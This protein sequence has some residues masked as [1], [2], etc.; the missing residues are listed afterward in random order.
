MAKLDDL[1]T[2]F[3]ESDK[4]KERVKKA[5]DSF[6]S[7]FGVGPEVEEKLGME[8]GEAIHSHFDPWGLFENP[9]FREFKVA[10]DKRVI[11]DSAFESTILNA[12]LEDSKEDQELDSFSKLLGGKDGEV[13]VKDLN[14]LVMSQ[15]EQLGIPM[16]QKEVKGPLH[17]LDILGP[18]QA[19]FKGTPMNPFSTSFEPSGPNDEGIRGT[20]ENI[21]G[22]VNPKT[23]S[24]FQSLGLES[25]EGSLPAAFSDPGS[26]TPFGSQLAEATG[27]V[28]GLDAELLA[29]EQDPGLQAPVDTIGTVPDLEALLGTDEILQL[30]KAV[31]VRV[32][33]PQSSTEM[34]DATRQQKLI[35][36]A[37]VSGGGSV[38]QAQQ[39]MQL[40]D[41]PMPA[42]QF[43]KAL[44]QI[45]TGVRTTFKE[46]ED[47]R[48]IQLR[49]AQKQQRLNQI[50]DR[51]DQLANSNNQFRHGSAV[52]MAELE[53]RHRMSRDSTQF[54]RAI[55]L[56]EQRSSNRLD[57]QLEVLQTQQA[58]TKEQQE[59][60]RSAQVAD[61]LFKRETAFELED[62]KHMNR[63]ALAGA[64][65]GQSKE[66]TMIDFYRDLARKDPELAQIIIDQMSQAP[67]GVDPMTSRAVVEGMRERINDYILTTSLQED[68]MDI[69]SNKFKKYPDSA[70]KLDAMD[71]LIFKYPIAE[72]PG[73]KQMIDE[74]KKQVISNVAQL[75]AAKGSLVTINQGSPGEREDLREA[76]EKVNQIRSIRALFNPSLTGQFQG[77]PITRALRQYSNG[78]IPF[79]KLSESDQAFLTSVQAMSAQQRNDLL[80]VA[81]NPNEIRITHGAFPSLD[82]ADEEFVVSLDVMERTQQ[83]IADYLEADMARDKQ[84]QTHIKNRIVDRAAYFEVKFKGT[85][86]ERTAFVKKIANKMSSNGFS[87]R[88]TEQYLRDIGVDF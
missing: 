37:V 22:N 34:I 82:M 75:G 24:I 13:R 62:L 48:Q 84:L 12:M 3:E 38:E 79:A 8:E 28:Q 50:L 72:F 55:A 54:G 14:P 1:L 74:A 26:L 56:E 78:L 83:D 11:L 86:E 73:A 67:D 39:L 59:L 20:T 36:A 23:S 16:P 65:E 46:Q 43:E 19:A 25:G 58:F 9:K 47:L 63:V 49:E 4:R 81:M 2:Q 69:Q 68:L 88:D 32:R 27:T 71:S 40:F 76:R 70:D 21:I 5:R 77:H 44:T 30:G 42:G 31:D 35:A 61:S 33:T 85:E 87:R 51:K 57:N 52:V 41:E 29:R 6:R 80:G 64:K 10:H 60:K 18:H 17:G 66:A 45:G 15:A 53:Q 7:Q